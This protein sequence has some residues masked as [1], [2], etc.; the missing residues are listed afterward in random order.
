MWQCKS[1]SE[2]KSGKYCCKKKSV[3]FWQDRCIDTC[4]NETCDSDSD[5][6]PP[7]ECCVRGKCVKGACL[8]CSAHSDCI[9]GNCCANKC[10]DGRC[11]DCASDADCGSGDVCCKKSFQYKAFCAKKCERE[12][13]NNNDDCAS[14]I[15]ECCR[16]KTCANSVSC[17][18]QCK[19]NSDCKSGKYCCKKKSVWFWQDRCSDT[20]IGAVCTSNEDCGPPNEYCISGK[21]SKKKSKG[22]RKWLVAIAIPIAI[23]VLVVLGVFIAMLC[24]CK[25]KRRSNLTEANTETSQM[26]ESGGDGFSNP[27]PPQ[28]DEYDNLVPTHQSPNRLTLELL[29]PANLESDGY[30]NPLQS[31][32]ENPADSG[33]VNQIIA[34]LDQ[35]S[36]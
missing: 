26:T 25:R 14:G 4:V 27:M 31:R 17:L 12:L 33:R 24:Y 2:C 8:E 29:N 1:N 10:V 35:P 30:V 28:V 21:C 3:W 32:T 34:F 36:F 15:G 22:F 5:C 9:S 23:A 16:N 20:C 13:C 18:W 11:Y 19:S 7:D 6:G